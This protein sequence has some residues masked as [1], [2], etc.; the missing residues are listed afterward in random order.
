MACSM[1]NAVRSLNQCAIG[2]YKRVSDHNQAITA[3]NTILSSFY[4]D[5]FLTSCADTQEA[6]TLANAVD[7]ILSSGCFRLLKRHSNK[8]V[9]LQHFMDSPLPGER[10]I[11]APIE[12]VRGLRWDPVTDDLL[13]KVAVNQH[14]GLLTKRQALSEVA[15][16][17]D[18]TGFL[19]PVV[20]SG[21]IFIQTLWSAGISWDEPLPSDLYEAWI[22]F[23]SSLPTLNSV[24]VPRWLGMNATERTTLCG[25]CDASQKAY[26][27]VVYTHT[28]KADGLSRVSLLTA[29]TKVAPLRGATIPRLEL[30]AA[31]LLAKTISDARVALNLVD[32]AFHL[33]SDSTIA[34]CWMRK[35][36]SI[37]RPYVAN[38][39]RQI[40]EL[41]AIDH[42]HYLRSAQ[43][44]AD[45]AS[46]GLTS[47]E[48]LVH[49]LW[50]EGPAWLR[51]K[52]T[53]FDPEPVLRDE[54]RTTVQSEEKLTEETRS[55][56][57]FNSALI[58]KAT[59]VPTRCR[60][61]PG[62]GRC[63]ISAN[64]Y[65]SRD[66]SCL[67]E[68]TTLPNSSPLVPFNPYLDDYDIV[69]V[70]GRIKNSALLETQRHPIILPKV[71][72]LVGLLI[73]QVH[74]ETLYGGA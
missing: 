33:W 46:R 65:R 55:N 3:R 10:D 2:N 48:I 56:Y 71:S 73:Q 49:D 44:P 42:W 60:D 5:D 69:R 67:R 23:R 72:D 63:L 22:K 14:S 50:W 26:A 61:H 30:C 39:V 16:L 32:S 66:I 70:G 20:I 35:Q 1:Y 57:S 51:E 43:N 40:Q 4:V 58:T 45:C 12:S 27:A 41:T 53:L 7:T 37:L 6:I 38:R 24:R 59:A 29:R 25:F 18:P 68:R 28:I 9:V 15:Q 54:E 64:T 52:Q 21:K 36:P 47:S 74:M 31:L 62:D 8:S 19:A 13:F 11:D 34:L 17:F